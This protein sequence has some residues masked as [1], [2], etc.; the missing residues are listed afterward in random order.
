MLLVPLSQSIEVLKCFVGLILV[1][2]GVWIRNI[3]AAPKPEIA[4]EA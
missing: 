3:V 4:A 1:K 2:R